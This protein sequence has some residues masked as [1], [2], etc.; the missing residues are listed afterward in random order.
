M[1]LNWKTTTEDSSLIKEIAEMA[2]GLAAEHGVE[3]KFMDA[4]MDIT[5]VHLNDTALDLERMRG[6]RKEDLA[7]DIF[8]IRRHI[9][10]ETGKLEDCF[11]PRFSK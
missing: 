6:A 2:V 7:H 5:A 4:I 11:L 10:R 3:Y 9:N 8:G 1:I